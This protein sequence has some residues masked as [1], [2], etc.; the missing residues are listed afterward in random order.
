LQFERIDSGD[1]TK[2]EAG[3]LFFASFRTVFWK[4]ELNQYQHRITGR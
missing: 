1:K 3:G 2:Y 4:F